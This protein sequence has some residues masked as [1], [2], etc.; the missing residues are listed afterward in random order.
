MYL[1]VSSAALSQLDEGLNSHT[2]DHVISCSWDVFPRQAACTAQTCGHCSTE[3]GGAGG[4]FSLP[5]TM[6]HFLERMCE[7]ENGLDVCVER[8]VGSSALLH[9]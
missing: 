9:S 5:N 1:V 6:K 2:H 4:S 8:N 3:E 7:E